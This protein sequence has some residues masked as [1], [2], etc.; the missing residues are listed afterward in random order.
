MTTLARWGNSAG[1]RL[2]KHVVEA[3]GLEIGDQI[4]V[5]LLDNGTILVSPI[6]TKIAVTEELALQ[7][8]EPRLDDW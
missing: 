4:G 1:L 3:A 7:K 5:R 6:K 8:K 2:P